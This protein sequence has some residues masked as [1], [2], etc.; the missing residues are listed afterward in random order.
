MYFLHCAE[1]LYKDPALK[2]LLRVSKHVSNC[3][4]QFA[5]ELG[6]KPEKVDAIDAENGSISNKCYSVLNT[7]L[8]SLQHPCW[9]EVAKALEMVDLVQMSKNVSDTYLSC[10]YI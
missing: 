8:K 5:V 1:H 4:M 2:E 6:L 7:W 9:C 10:K 3:W